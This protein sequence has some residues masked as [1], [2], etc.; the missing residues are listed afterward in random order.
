MATTRLLD[1][2]DLGAVSRLLAADP[3][4]GCLIATRVETAGVDARRLGA[5][6]W[7]YETGADRLDG[8]CLS[9]ANLVPLSESA[10]AL[11]GFAERAAAQGRR[12]SSIVGVEHAVEAVW[13]QLVGAWGP[14]RDVRAGQPLMAVSERSS[15]AP[16]P[17]VRV[18]VPAELDI[19][20]PACVAM[21]T[22]EVGVSPVGS[23]GGR[24]YRGRVRELIGAG[25]AYA[26][27]ENGEV[28]FK[29]ELGAVSSQACQI[30]GVWVRPDR[31]GQ[32]IGA[33]GTAAVVAAALDSVAP[34]VSLYVNDYNEQ[35]L[36]AYRRVGFRQVNT[37]MTVLFS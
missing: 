5:E 19:L 10:S 26:R 37:F 18:V 2:A 23:D 21:F 7:G 6:L 33:A 20:M 32:G 3:I 11:A 28:V 31:R 25:R 15:L 36:R 24:G 34:V 1:D 9:G 4:A 27:I 17:D 16:D 13:T 12:C 30:Q 35:A 22:E 29:A 8:L 14:A